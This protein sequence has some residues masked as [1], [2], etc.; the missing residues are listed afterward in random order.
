M[1]KALVILVI[2]AFAAPVLAKPAP[3]A[4]MDFAGVADGTALQDVPGWFVHGERDYDP[5]VG[6]EAIQ[7][8]SSSSE[9]DNLGWDFGA[10]LN[11]DW[12]FE[13]TCAFDADNFG[14]EP[15]KGMFGF[16]KGS[17]QDG[18]QKVA[19]D[20]D[21]DTFDVG[22]YSGE[23]AGVSIGD[24]VPFTI[25][26][27]WDGTNQMLWVNKD[28]STDTPDIVKNEAPNGA[29]TAFLSGSWG[30]GPV[31]WADNIAVYDAVPE[32]ASMSLLA[33]GGL[34]LLR[35]RRR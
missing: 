35:R 2:V 4:T 16:L 11:D 21:G 30:G 18:S 9:P 7:Y 25:A 6:G 10:T 5:V 28:F 27:G 19:I 3:I 8:I 14:Y 15:K 22:Y 24:E 23:R 33:L 12:V 1:K 20:L 13:V 34:A 17:Y 32:P 26:Y 31:G 29:P